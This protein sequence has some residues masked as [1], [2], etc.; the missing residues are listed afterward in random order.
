MKNFL[1]L[2]R[3]ISLLGFIFLFPFSGQANGE[4]K[5]R[6]LVVHSYDSDY[7][8]YPDYNRLILENF[9][10]EGVKVDLRIFYLDC[11][12]YSEEPEK[13]RIY[14]YL[15]AVSAWQ[16]DLILVNEDQA[17]YSTLACGHPLVTYTPVVFSGV[18]FPNWNLLKKFN[19]VTMAVLSMGMTGDYEVAIEE[20][21]TM[22][23]V[24]TGIFGERDYSK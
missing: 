8:V 23:R 10:K 11:E 24:G 5:F 20:G 1:F 15:D 17:T 13:Q 7:V 18:N 22:V 9:R 14:N 12:Q 16:P 2:V 21:A 3:F 19:N 4:K 6:V